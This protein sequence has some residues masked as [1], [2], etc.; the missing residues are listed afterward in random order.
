MQYITVPELQR[1]P[2]RF[3]SSVLYHSFPVFLSVSRRPTLSTMRTYILLPL[4]GLLNMGADA[5]AIHSFNARH[6]D[7]RSNRAMDHRYNAHSHTTRRQVHNADFSGSSS[8]TNSVVSAPPPS[9]ETSPDSPA[10]GSPSTPAFASAAAANRRAMLADPDPV[11][12]AVATV[13][14][15]ANGD[16]VDGQAE[17]ESGD[18]DVKKRQDPDPEALS[19]TVR[20]YS[21]YRASAISL[22]FLVSRTRNSRMTGRFPSAVDNSRV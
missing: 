13:L 19:V 2:A 4:L 16:V 20:V 10:S 15:D 17:S 21:V 22:L 5:A 3:S 12:D 6:P 8:S 9:A 7:P 1:P 18:T 14:D 11:A